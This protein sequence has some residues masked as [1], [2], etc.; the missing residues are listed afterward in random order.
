MSSTSR[1]NGNYESSSRN[2]SKNNPRRTVQFA[3]NPNESI[4][5]VWSSER[6]TFASSKT[7]EQRQHRRTNDISD[8]EYLDGE[9]SNRSAP[10]HH[11]LNG[12]RRKSVITFQKSQNHGDSG[13]SGGSVSTNRVGRSRLARIHLT[14][15]PLAEQMVEKERKKC[16]TSNA[17]ATQSNSWAVQQPKQSQ[18]RS[19]S[20][21]SRQTQIQHFQQRTQSETG[22]SELSVENFNRM[23]V[24]SSFFQK[25]ADNQA[26]LMQKQDN[27]EQMMRQI[28][29]KLGSNRPLALTQPTAAGNDNMHRNL[30][31]VGS[32]LKR[33][34]DGL[35]ETLAAAMNVDDETTNQA[36][37]MKLLQKPPTTSAA[38]ARNESSDGLSE[39]E[40]S[41]DV[42]LSMQS[43]L[44]LTPHNTNQAE[45]HGYVDD[46]VYRN[47]DKM[48]HLRNPDFHTCVFCHKHYV[49]I[50]HHYRTAH[51]DQEMVISRLA[52]AMA[53]EIQ[54]NR[55]KCIP[56]IRQNTLRFVETKC[57]FCEDVK[58]FSLH[59]WVDHIRGHTG[60]YSNKCRVC[61][62]NFAYPT[63]HCSVKTTRISEKFT[64]QHDLSGYLCLECNYVQIDEPNMLR[65][66]ETQ[67]NFDDDIF[68]T[69]YTRIIFIA[70]A[71]R[72]RI[73]N[74]LTT[75]ESLREMSDH[76]LSC[77]D[78]NIWF[79]IQFKF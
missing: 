48:R 43:D 54:Q 9:P 32:D 55:P 53:E 61:K 73:S 5:I 4:D 56:I 26:K 22:H 23:V 69:K 57:F 52:P 45:H 67:H 16:K 33:C 3:Q 72:S 41:Y 60:E 51:S 70:L 58:N 21:V 46:A 11:Q 38:A 77:V 28:L 65:H 78:G 39:S 30:S 15:S 1:F 25:M 75:L 29:A 24:K 76:N 19:Q 10:N 50:V 40:I 34:R 7:V 8:D 63:T 35:A 42:E 20:I 64:L 2:V 6:E 44:N 59:Y 66:L 37:R 71:R 31:R 17:V 14:S 68:D 74:P 79:E 18:S 47:V 12:N 36:K 13:G 49:R 62:A 27:L